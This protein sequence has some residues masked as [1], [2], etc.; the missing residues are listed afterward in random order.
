MYVS[1]IKVIYVF[2]VGNICIKLSV[3]VLE[4]KV[5][6]VTFNVWLVSCCRISSWC[7]VLCYHLFS[8]VWFFFF[9]SPALLSDCGISCRGRSVLCPFGLLGVAY[10]KPDSSRICILMCRMYIPLACDFL[11]TGDMF[12]PHYILYGYDYNGCSVSIF[13]LHY[14]HLFYIL[15]ILF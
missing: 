7:L 2:S 13:W 12:L 5:N 1:W 10:Y 6:L 9:I 15:S 3:A 11:C 4:W 8:S 14:V